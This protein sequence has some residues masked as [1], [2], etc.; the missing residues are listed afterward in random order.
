MGVDFEPTDSQLTD[1]KKC[2]QSVWTSEENVIYSKNIY[3]E[4]KTVA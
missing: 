3:K 1:N 4:L 2:D